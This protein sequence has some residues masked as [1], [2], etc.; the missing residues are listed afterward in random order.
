MATMKRLLW[1]LLLLALLLAAYLLLW[2][3]PIRA[4]AWQAPRFDGYVGA[5]ARNLRLAALRAITI[6]PEIGPEHIAFGPDGKLYTG[7]LSGAILRMNP[8]GTGVE[9]VA[10]TGGRPLG[11][12]FDAAGRLIV[13]DAFRGLLAVGTDHSVTVLVDHV[14]AEP[15]AFADAV[16]VA[17]DGR[18]YFTDA[19]Q[20][21]SARAWGTF[22]AAL[23][24]IMEHSCSGR[25]LEYRP[26]TRALR[27]VIGGLCFANG[28]ALSADES[29]MYVSETGAY[30]IWKVDV[31][32]DGLDAR[33]LAAEAAPRQARVFA[34]NLPGFPDNLTRSA[35]GRI[36]TGLTKPRSAVVDALADRPLLRE[37]S[38]RLPKAL[39]PVPPVY[40]HVIAFDESGRVVADLQDPA[41]RIPETSGVTEHDGNLYIQSLHAGA[42][43]VL[44]VAAIGP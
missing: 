34:D 40:G 42:L 1:C 11:M 29:Q 4:V 5:H 44:P 15:I 25:V 28:V 19:T 43:G 13:A 30:R 22:D 33:T 31:A 9:T 7:T 3:V 12:E 24:D 23:L 26:D 2:P 6:A 10:N 36:W 20:R 17:R 39:W 35:T 37:M 8:D 21:L 14:G 32:A 18:I 41:G 27:V 16:V 38:L